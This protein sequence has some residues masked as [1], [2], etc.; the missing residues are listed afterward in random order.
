MTWQLALKVYLYLL[1]FGLL[2]ALALCKAARRGDD[3]AEAAWRQHLAE[4]GRA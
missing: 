3:M 2:Y 1:P 4:R